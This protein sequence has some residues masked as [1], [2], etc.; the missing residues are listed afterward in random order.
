[1][2]LKRL[3]T[4]G[5]IAIVVGL[6]MPTAEA[7]HRSHVSVGIGFSTYPYWGGYGYY[8]YG[9]GYYP[10]GYGYSYYPYYSSGYYP[11]GSYNY[12]YYNYNRSGYRDSY[13]GGSMVA[14]VQRRLAQSGYYRGAID[15][16]M[17]P[18]TRAAIRAYE[19]SRGL[20]V[21]GVI[22]QQLIAT[23]GLRRY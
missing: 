11:Y 2:N 8:P 12:G 17:G 1:M 15:G 20:R 19:R 21:D 3:I 14:Q 5:A 13:A 16:V 7:R 4:L 18:R 23:M 22:S 6:A 9:Y 10:Y